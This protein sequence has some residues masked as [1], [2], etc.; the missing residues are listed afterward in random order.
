MSF[1]T[2]AINNGW[3]KGLT[4]DR[5]DN[6]G[7]YE[8]ENCQFIPMEENIVKQRLLKST[9]TSGYKGVSFIITEQKYAARIKIRG[10]DYFLGYFDNPIEAAHTYDKK[11]KMAND[12]RSINF[13]LG[14]KI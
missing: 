4:I 8:P 11:A 1:Y 5:V 3:K 10:Q 14:R 7:N 6:D 9:N 2:W 12:N 13:P